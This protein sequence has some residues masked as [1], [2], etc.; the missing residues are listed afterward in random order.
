MEVALAVDHYSHISLMFI[1]DNNCSDY[2]YYLV[3]FGDVA[4]RLPIV[5]LPASQS[6]DD[7]LPLNKLLQLLRVLDQ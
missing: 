5:G 2:N 3:H 7:T 1:V 6:M 4:S